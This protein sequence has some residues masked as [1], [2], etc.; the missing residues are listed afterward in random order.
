MHSK[1]TVAI[2]TLI[3]GAVAA[4]LAATALAHGNAV[5]TLTGTVGKNDAYKIA[6][7]DSTGRKVSTVKAGTYKLVIHD[8][9]T[10]T[11]VSFKGTKTFTL[12]LAAGKYKAYCAPH[13]SQMFQHFAV[14]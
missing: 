5:K 3:V 12:K 6:L 7:V 14:S 9:S 2:V 4:V 8:D 10:F 1:L 11:S 13:E